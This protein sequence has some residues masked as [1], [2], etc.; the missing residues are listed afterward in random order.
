MQHLKTDKRCEALLKLLAAVLAFE[1]SKECVCFPY[2]TGG[3]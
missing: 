3:Y 2:G 1:R